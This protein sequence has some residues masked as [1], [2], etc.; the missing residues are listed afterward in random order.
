LGVLVTIAYG[1]NTTRRNLRASVLSTSRLK[2]LEL[3]RDEIANL[4]IHGERIYS[5]LIAGDAKAL[6]TERKAIAAV[7]KKLIVLLGR[8]DTQRFALSDLVRRFAANPS[9]E[10]AEEI[11]VL[12]QRVFRAQWNKVRTETGQAERKKDPL[13]RRDDS[14]EEGQLPGGGAQVSE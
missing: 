6:L 11:E 2:W 3:L 9:R 7:S 8:E 10:L 13:E 1:L 5:P 12:S 4:L 14:G